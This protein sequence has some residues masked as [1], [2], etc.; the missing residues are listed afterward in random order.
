MPGYCKTWC[1][2]SKRT[3]TLTSRARA[4]A[5]PSTWLWRFRNRYAAGVMSASSRPSRQRPDSLCR[6]LLPAEGLPEM[7]TLAIDGGRPV[8]SAPFPPRITLD[9]TELEAVSGLI[10]RCMRG[11]AT[12]N[13]Y[14]GTQVD[15]FEKEFAEYF[16]TKFATGLSSG[17]GAIHA[18]LG[19]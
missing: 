14:G 9:E 3:A 17:T 7:S 2:L 5:R 19:A 12:L 4:R 18:A 1:G 15:T 8:R 16:G 11:E 13:R 10:K 6:R